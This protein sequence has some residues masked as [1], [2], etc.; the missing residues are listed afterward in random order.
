MYLTTLLPPD[1]NLTDES[2]DIPHAERRQSP[3][4]DLRD[5]STVIRVFF[6]EKARPEIRLIHTS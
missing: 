2:V 1:I 6:G 5:Q 4:C 3:D